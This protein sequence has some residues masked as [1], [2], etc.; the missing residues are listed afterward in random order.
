MSKETKK[1]P[2]V[3]SVLGTGGAVGMDVLPLDHPLQTQRRWYI[4]YV[5]TNTEK[6][7]RRQLEKLGYEVFVASQQE[8]RLYKNGDRKR[9]KMVERVI[10][11]HIVFIHATEKERRQLVTLPFISAFMMD[12]S[13]SQRAFATVPD[14]EM[15]TLR[16]MLGCSDRPVSFAPSGFTVGD[17][18]TVRG[19][20]NFDLTAEIVRLRGDNSSYVGVRIAALGCAY[21][22]IS[23]EYLIKSR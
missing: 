1:S 18:V 7:T 4:A 10:I 21:I 5:H 15:H 19:L 17:T 8:M 3:T 12:R 9:R 6:E 23:P 2:Q 14:L 16:L 20:G 13:Q 22:E 11:T